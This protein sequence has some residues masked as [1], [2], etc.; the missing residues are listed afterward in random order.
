MV[1]MQMTEIQSQKQ[2]V[3]LMKVL[4]LISSL[5]KL[6]VGYNEVK[7]PSVRLLNFFFSRM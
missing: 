4:R 5:L 7:I 2:L 3:E 1:I 6:H